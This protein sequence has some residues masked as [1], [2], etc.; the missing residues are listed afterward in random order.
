MT[1]EIKL[2]LNKLREGMQLLGLDAVV[3]NPSANLNYLTELNFHLSERP[4]IFILPVKGCPIIVLPELEITKIE[5]ASF[6]IQGYSY[7]EN[8]EM[9]VQVLNSA[10]QQAKLMN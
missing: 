9:W 1:V 2:R 7:G 5:D 4:V 6:F 8:P 10:L 3:I